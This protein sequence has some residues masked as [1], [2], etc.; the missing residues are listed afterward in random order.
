MGDTLNLYN[1]KPVIS[2]LVE[3]TDQ[4]LYMFSAIDK[5][6]TDLRFI[7]Y[8][9]SFRKVNEDLTIENIR[10]FRQIQEELLEDFGL[11]G[12]NIL[13]AIRLSKELCGYPRRY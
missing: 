2:L 12:I 4:E 6:S 10:D 3:R 7:E 11:P 1:K 9:E 8:G 13:R 5:L